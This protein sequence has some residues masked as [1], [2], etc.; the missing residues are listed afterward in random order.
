MADLKDGDYD[1]ADSHASFLD[2]LSAWRTAGKK[3]HP[4]PKNWT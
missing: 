3:Q 4:T 2:A 1:E